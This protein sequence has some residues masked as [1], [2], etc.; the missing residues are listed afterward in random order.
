ML[1]T[2]NDTLPCISNTLFPMKNSFWLFLPIAL[3]ACS[4]K[5]SVSGSGREESFPSAIAIPT[6]GNSWVLNEP[7]KSSELITENG[8]TNWSEDADRIGTYFH[9]SRPGKLEVSIR[10]RIPGGMTRL[11]CSLGDQ[12][13]EIT[14]SNS[15]WAIVPVGTFEVVQPGYQ[16]LMWQCLEH[17]SPTIAE[18]ESV[19][20]AGPASEGEVHFVRDEFYWGR[21]GPSVH[22][23]FPQA[24]NIPNV[25]W[26]YSEI[27][28]PA[29]QDVEGSYFMANGF[30]EGYFGFQVNSESERRIL[31]SVWSPFKT[32]DPQSIPE[33]QKIKLLR[34]G[35]NVHTGEFGN[36]GSGGQSYLRYPWQ[37]EVTYRFLLHARPTGNNSTDYTA[38]FYAPEEGKWLLIAGWRRP[39]TDTYLTSLYSFLE[40][41]IP[42]TGVLTRS[43]RYGNQ[44]ICD[45]RGQWQELTQAR[46]TADATARKGNR[47][48][49]AGGAQGDAFFLK[50]CGFFNERTEMDTTFER[51]ATGGEPAVDLANFK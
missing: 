31:F 16:Q 5:E 46:F 4:F 1:F 37:A 9:L 44:W 42:E 23:R 18:I 7:M 14:L 20:L 2:G 19:R 3:L 17:P 49:Y 34:K 40:N 41:F 48:D 6:A 39:K 12:S 32:D 26:F 10:A 47:L 11:K 22:L 38:W 45:A 29:G 21:R 33:G 28:V 27:T 8:L 15:D 24:D 51:K 35:Q 43:A 36:E 50:N 25:E 30:G 13:Q